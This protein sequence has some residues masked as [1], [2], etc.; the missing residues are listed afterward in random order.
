[1]ATSET[2]R[3]RNDGLR[4]S[5]GTGGTIRRLTTE[6]KSFFKTSEFVAYVVV[7]VGILI[8]AN[9][10]E[11]AEGGRDFFT[12]DKAWLYI[13]VLTVGYMISR[14][15]AKAGVRDPYWAERGDSDASH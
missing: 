9:S 12:A 1:M 8:A 14:G 7:A 3:G 15:I 11:N 13:T 4:T 6:T 5:N 2:T 10:I